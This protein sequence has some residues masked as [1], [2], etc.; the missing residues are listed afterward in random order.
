ML[1]Y[2]PRPNKSNFQLI[3]CLL[4]IN[5][6]HF[7]TSVNAQ[8][9]EETEKWI[10]EKLNTLKSVKNIKDYTRFDDGYSSIARV[11]YSPQN[12]EIKD[13]ILSHSYIET[14]Y[15][16]YPPNKSEEKR[17]V[18]RHN[19]K[20]P[21]NQILSFFQ[22]DKPNNIQGKDYK[23]TYTADQWLEL[24]FSSK[25]VTHTE[26]NLETIKTNVFSLFIDSSAEEDIGNRLLNAF[27]QLKTFYPK[28]K[29]TF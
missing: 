21:I 6:L 13:G 16:S 8:T 26:N 4:L 3:S 2:K 28:P 29:E 5:F 15:Y 14:H 22:R 7:S 9:K 12:F 20:A 18:I 11:E 17:L 27:N 25:C 10:L 24:S 23:T 19:N 1:M